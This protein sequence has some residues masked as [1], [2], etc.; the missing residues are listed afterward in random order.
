MLDAWNKYSAD[1]PNLS[2]SRITMETDQSHAVKSS[3]LIAWSV[4]VLLS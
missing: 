3:V 2:D 4:N 1:Y